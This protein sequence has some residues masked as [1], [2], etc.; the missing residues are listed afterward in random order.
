MASPTNPPSRVVVGLTV[1]E[2]IGSLVN[3]IYTLYVPGVYA[4]QGIEK[5]TAPQDVAVVLVNPAK[6]CIGSMLRCSVLTEFVEPRK[7]IGTVSP[8]NFQVELP[9]KSGLVEPTSLYHTFE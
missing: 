6:L 1:G 5:F 4:V 8:S 9:N 2:L 3:P 7:L